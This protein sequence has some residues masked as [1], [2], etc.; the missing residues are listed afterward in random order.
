M[1][2]DDL[3]DFQGFCRMFGVKVNRH[4]DIRTT[5]EAIGKPGTATAAYTQPGLDIRISISNLYR[6]IEMLKTKGYFHDDTYQVRMREEELIL[7]HPELRNLHDQYKTLLYML[8][9]HS[10]E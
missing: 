4:V 7:T 6:I 9:G 3:E 5:T 2:N 8:A 1:T 10:D